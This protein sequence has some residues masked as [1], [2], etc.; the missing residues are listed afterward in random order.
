MKVIALPSVSPAKLLLE[1]S[2]MPRSIRNSKHSRPWLF[3]MRQQDGNP[4]AANQRSTYIIRLE[5]ERREHACF[6]WVAIAL[7]AF[8]VPSLYGFTRGRN[9]SL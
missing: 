9:A 4:I 3:N 6:V 5:P 2:K 1:A 7:E 8:I